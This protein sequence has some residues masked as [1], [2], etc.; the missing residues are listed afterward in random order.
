MSS[1]TPPTLAQQIVQFQD[2]VALVHQFTTGGA[3]DVVAT[4]NGEFPTL[5]SLV[6]YARDCIRDVKVSHSETRSMSY[7]F[8]NATVVPIAHNLG[9]KYF[10]LSVFDTNGALHIPGTTDITENGFT[11][12]FTQAITGWVTVFLHNALVDVQERHEP[13]HPFHEPQEDC[14]SSSDQ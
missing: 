13:H 14:D 3:D 6:Q 12:Q 2:D 10:T 5:S 8:T 7:T 1:S 9:T 11:I 4:P